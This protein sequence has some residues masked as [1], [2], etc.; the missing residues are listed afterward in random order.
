MTFYQIQIYLNFN[1][2]KKYKPGSEHIKFI[3]PYIIETLILADADNP[4]NKE[5]NPKV[6]N[7]S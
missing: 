1:G 3:R 5:K 2:N 7:T 4:I 6:K